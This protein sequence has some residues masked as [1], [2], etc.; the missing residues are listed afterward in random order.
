MSSMS[1]RRGP[2]QQP[3]MRVA[4]QRGVS[5]LGLLT[6]AIVFGFLG[7]VAIRVLPTVN[8]Y[9]TIQSAVDKIAA[10]NPTTVGE[11]RTAFDRQKQIEYS[12]SSISSKD[13]DVT[14][15]NDKVVISFEYDKEIEVVA[16]LYLLLRYKGRSK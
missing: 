9:M 13:L 3:R 1:H 4:R 8:E 12:I 5:L 16:P 10:A 2:I 7:Y 6:W 14:K 11:V 15:E